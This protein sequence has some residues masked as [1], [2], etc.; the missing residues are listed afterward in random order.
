M[1]ISIFGVNYDRP[2]MSLMYVA[3]TLSTKNRGRNLLHF[4]LKRIET[5][6]FLPF[7]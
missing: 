2:A 3:I 5:V 6:R 7:I 1:S 4:E